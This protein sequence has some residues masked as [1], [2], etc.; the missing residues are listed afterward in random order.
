MP[1]SAV[2]LHDASARKIRDRQSFGY[3]VAILLNIELLETTAI[4]DISSAILINCM[5]VMLPKCKRD[6]K[7]V[8]L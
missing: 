7:T 2:L 1:F 3:S 8:A 6:K 4:N 5:N